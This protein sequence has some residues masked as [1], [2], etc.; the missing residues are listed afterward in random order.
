[1]RIC[2]FY[3]IRRGKYFGAEPTGGAEVDVRVRNVMNEKAAVMDELIGEMIKLD[4][5]AV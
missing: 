4:L 3:E 2:G 5:E 1:M